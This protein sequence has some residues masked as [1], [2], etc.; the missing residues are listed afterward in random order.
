MQR[1]LKVLC[2]LLFLIRTGTLYADQP[3]MPQMATLAQ[4]P[5]WLK[6]LHYDAAAGRSDIISPAFFISP[7]GQSDPLA[8]L[9]A[10][11][12][13]MTASR[14]LDSDQHAQCRFPARY[15][16]LQQQL[17]WQPETQADCTAFNHWSPRRELDSLSLIYATGYLDNPASFYG[18]LM[19][20]INS[21]QGALNDHLL[22]TSIN[23]GA[24]IP[25][26]ENPLIYIA[27]GLTG[28][29]DAGFTQDT[30]YR[31]TQTYG[32]IEL[33]DMWDYRLQLSR[34]D[35]ELIVAHLWEL[36][37]QRFT[38]YYLTRNCAYRIVELLQLVTETPLLHTGKPWVHPVDL[39]KQLQRVNLDA[40]PLLDAGHYI[41]SRQQRFYRRFSQLS[42]V[43]QQ[44]LRQRIDQPGGWGQGE[45]PALTPQQRMGV[46]DVLLDYTELQIG[47]TDQLRH[48]RMQQQL[49]QEMLRLSSHTDYRAPADPTPAPPHQGQNSSAAGVALIRRDGADQLELSLRSSY[50]DL[51]NLDAGR[52]PWSQLLMLDLQLRLE[53]NRVQVQQ[54]DLLNIR[55]YGLPH[56]GLPGD[57]RN[58]WSLRAGWDRPDL[59][60]T[61]CSVASLDGSYG[62][63]DTLGADAAWNISLGGR[64]AEGASGYGN[65]ALGGSGEL[66]WSAGRGYRARIRYQKLRYIDGQRPWSEGLRVEQRFG[67]GADWDLRLTYAKARGEE[68]RLGLNR[69]F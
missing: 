35:R 6:L 69:Y 24:I 18:H 41:P 8:E 47:R 67:S 61:R 30:F 55:T 45:H 32:N 13:A 62:W 25:A 68:W 26:A 56:T 37:G 44:A 28:G 54:L 9:T 59:A 60:C 58:A 1:G 64:T 5:Q 31:Q 65:L 36:L 66:L 42:A 7:D 52:M 57:R 23:Y 50:F 2:W 15:R 34:D 49:L 51:L 48:R 22:D 10:T 14:A 63:S 4:H 38:Y 43:Q 33:R 39:L 53:R 11:L 16:W 29:Y 21:R 12:H 27:K 3:S 40:R 19:L 20:R 46:V 17:H